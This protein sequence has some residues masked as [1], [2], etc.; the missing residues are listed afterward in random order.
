MPGFDVIE[1]SLPWLNGG[2]TT[3]ETNQ[4][5]LSGTAGGRD[6]HSH[7]Q[8]FTVTARTKYIGQR[9]GTLLVEL[10]ICVEA[11]KTVAVMKTHSAC[12]T[13]RVIV[14]IGVRRANHFS[15]KMPAPN[16][17]D[18]FKSEGGSWGVCGGNV[19]GGGLAL[20]AS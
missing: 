15:G 14:M 3:H 6:S 4:P 9:E 20:G 7:W 13:L 19:R 1:G 8:L 17:S 10:V 18:L 5:R 16:P 2:S 11:I 12:V